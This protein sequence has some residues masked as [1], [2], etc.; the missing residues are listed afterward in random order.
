MSYQGPN[1]SSE[2]SPEMLSALID[3]T[4]SAGFNNHS[5]SISMGWSGNN[6]CNYEMLI[7]GPN[8]NTLL[9]MGFNYYGNYMN[10][11]YLN[12][13][14]Q[15]F[16]TYENSNPYFYSTTDD[17]FVHF[18]ENALGNLETNI[19]FISLDAPP[20]GVYTVNFAFYGIDPICGI[21]NTVTFLIKYGNEQISFDYPI[22]LVDKNSFENRKKN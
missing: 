20:S 19:E 22:H 5:I 17:G 13:Y 3:T 6:N 21:G 15:A 9:N 7:D 16:D 1:C 11:A 2:A 10:M 12:W 14:D 4:V 18:S 8:S